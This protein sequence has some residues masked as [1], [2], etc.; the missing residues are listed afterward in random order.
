MT[1]PLFVDFSRECISEFKDII[2][3]GNYAICESDKYKEDCPF[4]KS[5]N[6]IEPIC[7]FSD[8]C[9]MYFHVVTNDFKELISM[10]KK[11]CFSENYSNCARYKIRKSGENPPKELYPDGKLIK[12]SD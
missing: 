11:Y 5:I 12:L 2:H 9:P 8:K 10:T 1:C 4:Y 7:E 6:K 3:I